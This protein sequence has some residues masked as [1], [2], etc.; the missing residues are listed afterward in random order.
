MSDLQF[1]DNL[2][3]RSVSAQPHSSQ[4]SIQASTSVATNS[5][6]VATED[7]DIMRHL[8]SDSLCGPVSE[9]DFDLDSDDSVWD[10]L[11]DDNLEDEVQEEEGPEDAVQ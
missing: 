5:E 4:S 7:E 3:G 8:Q 10:L 9:L 6:R 11:F 1:N 2:N